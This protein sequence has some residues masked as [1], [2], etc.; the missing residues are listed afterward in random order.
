MALAAAPLDS[1]N[2]I[3]IEAR[4]WLNLLEEALTLALKWRCCCLWC[5]IDGRLGATLWL[6]LAHDW[7]TQ[8]LEKL[9]IR[10]Q[11]TRRAEL[12]L[13][14]AGAHQISQR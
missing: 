14:H 13:S 5:E 7:C 9:L 3:D 11:L 2:S 8:K 12:H 4:T 10:A 6:W 1:A